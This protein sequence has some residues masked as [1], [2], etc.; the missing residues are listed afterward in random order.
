M[1]PQAVICTVIWSQPQTVKQRA[2][3]GGKQA[4]G[5][6]SYLQLL[7]DRSGPASAA[8]AGR[9]SPEGQKTG[10]G[11]CPSRT[12]KAPGEPADLVGVDGHRHDGGRVEDAPPFG[13]PGAGAGLSHLR[14]G[15][16]LTLVKVTSNYSDWRE[17]V[18]ENESD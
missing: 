15:A 14:G 16:V 18:G 6:R 8:A 7:S 4:R 1:R 3:R 2:E 11:T 10:S 13:L 9:C 5:V 17:E 12:L